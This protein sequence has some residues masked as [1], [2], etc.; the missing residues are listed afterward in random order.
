MKPADV[1]CVKHKHQDATPHALHT[2]VPPA[3]SPALVASCEID[4]SVRPSPSFTSG[5]DA[6]ERRID[7]FP[8]N[9]LRRYA[10]ERNEPGARATS[11]MRPYLH[12]GHISA[13]E[14][15]R[16]VRGYADEHKLVAENIWRS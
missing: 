15:A 13:L 7:Y 6:A 12:S 14:I 10:R 1:V 16:S 11:G 5:R 8:E 2:E 4:H 3:E 9:N